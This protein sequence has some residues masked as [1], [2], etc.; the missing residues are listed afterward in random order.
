MAGVTLRFFRLKDQTCPLLQWLESIKP[1]KAQA[2]VLARI[3]LLESLGHEIRRPHADMLED[4]IYELR[5][6]FVSVQY[7]ALFF[8]NGKTEAV[9][10]HGFTK[11]G[12]AVPPKEIERAK[13]YRAMFLRAPEMHTY[14]E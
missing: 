10:T 14:E 3:Q 4:G 8:F 11:E 6:R 12:S 13:L 2:K 7:R 9:I 1:K 5:E